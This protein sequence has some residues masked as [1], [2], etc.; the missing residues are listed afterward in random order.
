MESKRDKFRRLA[1]GRTNQAIKSIKSLSK[2]SNKNHY[3]FTELEIKEIHR[4]IKDELDK[5][6]LAFLKN[7]AKVKI[8]KFSLPEVK[9]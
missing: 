4:V 2:L 6:R 9:D 5:T 3:E 8:N 7:L 1:E